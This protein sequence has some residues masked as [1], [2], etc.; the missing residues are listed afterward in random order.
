MSSQKEAGVR[1]GLVDVKSLGTGIRFLS[2]PKP[3]LKWPILYENQKLT[4]PT[5]A[6][7]REERKWSEE[8]SGNARTTGSCWEIGRLHTPHSLGLSSALELGSRNDQEGI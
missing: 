4:L 2:S 1:K 8:D 7:R 6:R 5:C 3:F